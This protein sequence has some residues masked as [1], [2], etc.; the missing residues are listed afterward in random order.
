[1][2]KER[3]RTERRME[4]DRNRQMEHEILMQKLREQELKL[5]ERELKMIAEKEERSNQLIKE[6]DERR[7]RL[8][9]IQMPAPMTSK[10]DLLE[11]LELFE[12][13]A[14]TKEIPQEARAVALLPLLNDKYRAVATKLSTE[15]QADY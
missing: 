11:C 15:V 9:T 7:E 12:R 6:R 4:E 3:L 14:N 2:E 10:T 13:V 5:K 8:N 1:M